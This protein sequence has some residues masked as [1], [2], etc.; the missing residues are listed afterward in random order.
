M[1]RNYR[2]KNIVLIYFFNRYNA[3]LFADS[4]SRWAEAVSE[5]SKCFDNSYFSGYPPNLR[6]IYFFIYFQ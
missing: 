4:T 5:I 1:K 2:I 6:I 3:S